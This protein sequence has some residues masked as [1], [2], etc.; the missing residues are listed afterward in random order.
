M[1]ADS[2]LTGWT[3]MAASCPHSLLAKPAT[4]SAEKAVRHKRLAGRPQALLT[5]YCAL[6]PGLMGF[7]YRVPRAQPCQYHDNMDASI[8]EQ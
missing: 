6:W 4:V 5:C 2:C 8:H 7:W 3:S 1:V